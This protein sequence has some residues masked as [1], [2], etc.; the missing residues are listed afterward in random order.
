MMSTIISCFD[1]LMTPRCSIEFNQA[2]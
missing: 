1:M 2:C